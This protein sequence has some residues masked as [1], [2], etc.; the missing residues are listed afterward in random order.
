LQFGYTRYKIGSGRLDY[1]P[2]IKAM[3]TPQ[4]GA[5]VAKAPVVALIDNYSISLS[6][7]VAMSVHCLPNGVLIGETTWGATGPITNNVIYNDGSFNVPGFLSVYT[8]SA[9]FKYVNGKIYEGI[10]FPPDIAISVNASLVNAGTDQILD[11][12]ISLVQ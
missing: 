11:K 8:S 1:T 6:E 7:A 3:I 4:P 5:N 10:G 9:A 12:A 2:W